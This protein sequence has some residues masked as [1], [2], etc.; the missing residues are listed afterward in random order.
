MTNTP[1]PLNGPFMST[2]T[3]TDSSDEPG[4]AV[5]PLG[6]LQPVL[7]AKLATVR[8]ALVAAGIAEPLARRKAWGVYEEW[9]EAVTGRHTAE[10]L[11]EYA[12]RKAG[13]TP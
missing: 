9:L 8:E 10:T 4:Y 5:P 7:E 3:L 11:A 6:P 1:D 2:R 13:R 12:T